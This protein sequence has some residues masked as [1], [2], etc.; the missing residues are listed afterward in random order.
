DIVPGSPA[1]VAGLERNDVVTKLG[2]KQIAT[3]ADL[4]EAVRRHAPGDEVQVEFSRDQESLTA[5]LELGT[6]PPGG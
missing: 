1:A 3:N 6:R 2:D 4:T 5:T